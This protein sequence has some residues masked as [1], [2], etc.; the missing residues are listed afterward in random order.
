MYDDFAKVMRSM[1]DM[2]DSVACLLFKPDT[3]LE[4]LLNE[5]EYFITNTHT[6]LKVAIDVARL[7][8]YQGSTKCIESLNAIDDYFVRNWSATFVLVPPLLVRSE[9][10]DLDDVVKVQEWANKMNTEWGV[11]PIFPFRWVMFKK[12]NGQLRHV[13]SSWVGNSD[14]LSDKGATKYFRCIWKYIQ[15]TL[16]AQLRPNPDLNSR[17]EP[18]S[19]QGVIYELPQVVNHQVRRGIGARLSGGGRAGREVNPSSGSSG[20][21]DGLG[22]ARLTIARRRVSREVNMI[23]R[24]LSSDPRNVNTNHSEFL[25]QMMIDII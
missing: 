20:Q 2:D 3:T 4:E 13:I 17:I 8:M 11:N 6:E 7:F 18:L 21:G 9:M 19:R 16:D 24:L 14:V 1:P 12:K 15:N 23:K 10:Q 5:L 25:R 22:D